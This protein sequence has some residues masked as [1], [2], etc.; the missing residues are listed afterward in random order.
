MVKGWGSDLFL[1][2]KA[3]YELEGVGHTPRGTHG[4]CH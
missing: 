2:Y 4:Q 1:K 3:L